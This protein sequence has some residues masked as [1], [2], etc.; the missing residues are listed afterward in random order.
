[1]INPMS[2]RPALDARMVAF[3]CG[4]GL[5]VALLAACG[6]CPSQ[7][8]QAA[9]PEKTKTHSFDWT[10]LTA[11]DHEAT[12]S[13][14]KDGAP[15]EMCQSACRSVL[16]DP[17]ATCQQVCVAVV[18]TT[19]VEVQECAFDAQRTSVTYM[20]HWPARPE[21]CTCSVLLRPDRYRRALLSGTGAA[22][23]TLII[24]QKRARSVRALEAVA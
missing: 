7:R 2:A 20:Y 17:Q 21:V 15:L 14:L 11:S 1:M 22:P 13:V 16:L 8:F 19:E 9:E 5:V 3:A 24:E 23:K 4:L 12:G 6:P 10:A 18:N